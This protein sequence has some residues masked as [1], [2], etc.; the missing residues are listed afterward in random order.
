LA[1]VAA[2]SAARDPPLLDC[3]GN[4]AEN[5]ETLAEEMPMHRIM[6]FLPALARLLMAT[7]F[8]WD[9]ILQLRNPAGTAKYFAS[10]HVP[11]PEV[12]VWISIFVHLLGGLALVLG[13]QAR[14]AAAILCLLCLGTA[15]GVHLPVG[16]FTNMMHF[17]K[18]LAIAGG[19]LYVIAH[20]PGD[21][22]INGRRR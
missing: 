11:L 13:F 15:F 2:A 10:V 7:L 4:V 6:A 16:D 12:T 8:I 21:L 22:S 9:G 1:Y 19:L 17:Y 5:S 20:G 3:T 14:W 18:N